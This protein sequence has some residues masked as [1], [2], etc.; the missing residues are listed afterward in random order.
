MLKKTLMALALLGALA[1]PAASVH[2]AAP[3]TFV[4]GFAN[5]AGDLPDQVGKCADNEFFNSQNGDEEQH[6]STGGLLVWRKADNWTAFTD[7]YHTWI[8]GPNGLE[9]RLNTDRFPWEPVTPPS[10]APAASAAAPPA[11]PLP[12][13]GASI[14]QVPDGAPPMA[15]LTPDQQTACVH[16]Y[17]DFAKASTGITTAQGDDGACPYLAYLTH[18]TG[19]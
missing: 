5:L 13:A 12:A 19:L 8:N 18:Q 14:V 9:E 7:G 3:C 17:Q 4:L 16:L 11:A 15:W 6:T 1:A 10:P 2:A